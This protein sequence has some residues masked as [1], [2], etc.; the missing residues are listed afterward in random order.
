[1]AAA[2]LVAATPLAVEERSAPGTA[3]LLGEGEEAGAQ[4]V[5]VEPVTTR[6]VDWVASDV[7]QD[8]GNA[9]ASQPVAHLRFEEQAFET[10]PATFDI[11]DAAPLP[12]ISADKQEDG[13]AP[14]VASA[15]SPFA[16][17][18]DQILLPAGADAATVADA[19]NVNAIVGGAIE[20]KT[21]DLDAVLAAYADPETT[22]IQSATA[23][24][25]DFVMPAANEMFL[26]DVAELH[27]LAQMEQAAALGQA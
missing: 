16:A 9:A 6:A 7:D 14:P 12:S 13:S 17:S 27:I 22:P 10:G 25:S 19:S 21:I 11:K 8:V 5:M 26:P 15:A 23:I 24:M 4:S 1:L 20:G 2:G 18:A 3:D